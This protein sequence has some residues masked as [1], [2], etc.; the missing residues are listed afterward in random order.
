[1]T[2]VAGSGPAFPDPGGF[3]GDGGPA[4]EARLRDPAAV[5][6][7]GAG[8]LYV[9]DRRNFRV[10]KVIGVPMDAPGKKIRASI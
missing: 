2:T 4:T 9:T 6:I 10:R 8:N 5:A 3:A 1:M 7:D